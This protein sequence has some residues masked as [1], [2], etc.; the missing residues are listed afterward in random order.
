MNK[1]RCFYLQDS[2]GNYLN[3]ITFFKRPM[4]LRNCTD[5]R[6]AIMYTEKQCDKYR[7]YFE[8]KRVRCYP[9]EVN[10]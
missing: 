5:R 4:R 8:E 1:I 7:E 6:D 10:I 2:K 9:I 3:I